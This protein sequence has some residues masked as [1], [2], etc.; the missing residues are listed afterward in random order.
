M[1]LLLEGNSEDIISALQSG[2]SAGNMAAD[3]LLS[4][5]M[6][7]LAVFEHWN[8]VYVP[9]HNNFLARNVAKRAST[10]NF[11]E[12]V[13]ISLLPPWASISEDI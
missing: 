7:S 12:P 1:A 6:S 11:A 2:D 13:N 10:C 4:S 8:V 9:R 3:K 5:M